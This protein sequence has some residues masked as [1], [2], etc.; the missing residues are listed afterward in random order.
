VKVSDSPC[1]YKPDGF[2]W[3]SSC[4]V[5]VPT[6]FSFFGYVYIGVIFGHEAIQEIL[7]ED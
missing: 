2:F 4:I 7:G 6:V 3:V 5:Q 1:I